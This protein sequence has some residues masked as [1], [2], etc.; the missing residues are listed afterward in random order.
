MCLCLSTP[1]CVRLFRLEDRVQHRNESQNTSPGVVLD[2]S[3]ISEQ[4]QYAFDWREIFNKI[5]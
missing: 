3:S 5:H 2:M 1:Q 4:Y